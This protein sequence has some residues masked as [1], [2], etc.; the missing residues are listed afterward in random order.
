[1]KDLPALKKAAD[2]LEGEVISACRTGYARRPSLGTARGVRR[3]L[4]ALYLELRRGE[5]D[6]KH[7]T[8]AAYLLKTILEAIRLDE[9]ETRLAR[10]EERSTK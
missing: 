2:A 7:A 4:A 1:M 9:I 3:E 5:I 10:L 8:S 6:E